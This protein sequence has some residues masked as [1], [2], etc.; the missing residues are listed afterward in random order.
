MSDCTCLFD[1]IKSRRLYYMQSFLDFGK[2]MDSVVFEGQNIFYITSA[3]GVLLRRISKYFQHFVCAAFAVLAVGMR[4]MLSSFGLTF[5]RS[6]CR[7]SRGVR[8]NCILRGKGR[9]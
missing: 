6:L 8:G 7:S 9:K 1:L 4:R 3:V 2:T 5:C